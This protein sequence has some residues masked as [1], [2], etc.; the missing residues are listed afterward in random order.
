M[1]SKNLFALSLLLAATALTPLLSRADDSTAP[2]PTP[3][4]PADGTQPPAGHA[5]QR[6][7]G[8]GPFNL[9]ELTAKLGLTADQQKTIGDIINTARSQG[10][11]VHDDDSLSA[12]DKRAKMK[13]IYTTARSQIR[14]ALTPE[15]QATFDAMPVRQ[16][17]GGPPPAAAPTPPPTT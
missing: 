6:R 8:G 14:E 11:E 3:T 10:R 17:P 1:K 4:A 12:D 9:K 5:G 15:Q 2:T 13:E 7:R 16:G